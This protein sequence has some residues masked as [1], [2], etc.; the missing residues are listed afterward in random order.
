M[1]TPP[2]RRILLLLACVLSTL[3]PFPASRSRGEDGSL[4]RDGYDRFTQVERVQMVLLPATVTD[5][6]GRP[7]L[8]LRRE[9]FILLEDDAP[10]RIEYFA[11]EAE[12]PVALAFLLDVSGSMRL[13]GR[14]DK[15]K[16]AIGSFVDGLGA[17]DRF[18]LICFADDQ[19][20]WVTPFSSDARDFKL[21][22]SVQEG[23]GQTALYDA[24]AASPGMV[25]ET[26]YARKAIVLFTDGLDNFSSLNPTE[27][28]GLARQVS[29]PIYAISF[30]S[31][32][33]DMISEE[34]RRNLAL[35]ERFSAETGGALFTIHAPEEMDRAIAR[36][37]QDLRSQYV[38]GFYPPDPRNDP[39]FRHIKLETSRSRLRV[40][41]RTGY[42][43]ES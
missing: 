36:I 21:R 4:S 32:P 41:T 16:S 34:I 43:P 40:R 2:R 31:M 8:N 14:L 25:D 3:A 39:S 22:L 20:T 12:A 7:V 11:T 6:R 29:V 5:R 10:T 19:V 33:P 15:S 42:Y 18:G 13:P 9:D 30:I 37:Q 27:A 23:Y 35:L 1:P 28:I 38:I 24:L 26:P 17:A